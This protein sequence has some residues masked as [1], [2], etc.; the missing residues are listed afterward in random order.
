M[1]VERMTTDAAIPWKAPE[2]FV[3]E[4][5][6]QFGK[7]L[8]VPLKEYTM[9]EPVDRIRALKLTDEEIWPDR[10]E[11]AP[12]AREIRDMAYTKLLTGLAELLERPY[13]PVAHPGPLFTT[14]MRTGEKALAKILRE[15]LTDVYDAS[16]RGQG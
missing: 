16:Y 10:F 8:P 7:M 13:E 3:L 2:W 1:G 5:F 9:T 12:E 14:G 4:Y 15:A 11:V 6:P